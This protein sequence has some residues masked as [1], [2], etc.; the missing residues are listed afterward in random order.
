MRMRMIRIYLLRL[1]KCPA[2]I[3]GPSFALGALVGLIVKYAYFLK[4]E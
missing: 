1:K 4:Q 2:G 3:A